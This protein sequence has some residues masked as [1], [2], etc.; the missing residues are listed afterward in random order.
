LSDASPGLTVDRLAKLVASRDI[1]T[2]VVGITDMQGRLQGKRFAAAHFLEEVV[3]R[4]TEG[5][6][7]L[8]AVDVEMNTVAGYAMPRGSAVTATSSWRPICRRYGCFHGIP[9]RLFCCADVEW[10][11]GTPVVAAPRQ[12]LR[13]Q[14][15]RLEVHGWHALAATEL[16]FIVFNDTFEDAWQVGYRNLTP[17][18]LYNVDYSLL[19]TGRWSRSCDGS[20]TSGRG[21]HVG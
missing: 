9:A 3:T 2:V 10:A 8:L 6:N 17:A 16:E 21:G 13:R 5:C 1:D 12:I 11:D 7:Y 20:A 14:S 4:G 18:N 15:E 19:G